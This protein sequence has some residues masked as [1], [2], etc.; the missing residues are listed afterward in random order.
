MCYSRP[1]T[2]KKRFK[3]ETS[4]GKEMKSNLK[5]ISSVFTTLMLLLFSFSSIAEES[6][7]EWQLGKFITV[8]PKGLDVTFQ[9]LEEYDPNQKL[10]MGWNGEESL[11]TMVVDEQ[12]G[13]EKV[14]LY[15]KGI[16][17][18][19]KKTSAIDVAHEG[20]FTS[21]S[22]LEITY[23]VIALNIDGQ[24]VLQIYYLVRN[25]KIAYWAIAH[26]SDIETVNAAYQQSARVLKTVRLTK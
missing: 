18:E 6:V 10:V 9:L 21:N 16:L 25:D 2:K 12:P 14:E 13:G 22:G 24:P 5:K 23:K 19:M 26:V 4:W 7:D 15:W 17:Q 3:I 1:I 11:F 8:A 20:N